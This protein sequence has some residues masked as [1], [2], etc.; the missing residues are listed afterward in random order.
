MISTEVGPLLEVLPPLTEPQRGA[1]TSRPLSIYLTIHT[2]DRLVRDLL[3]FYGEDCPI[4]VMYDDHGPGEIT[5]GTL[6]T[7]RGWAD[8]LSAQRPMRV[9][10]G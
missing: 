8:A 2:L 10:V 6:A 3:P 7:I 1:R 9:L 5:Q 4:A